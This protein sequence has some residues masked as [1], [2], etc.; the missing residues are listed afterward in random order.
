MTQQMTGQRT[1]VVYHA[2]CLDGFGAAWAAH[3]SLGDNNV[4]YLPASYG[5]PPPNFRTESRIFILDFSYPREITLE[6]IGQHQVTVLDHHE[7][8]EESIGDLPG[9]LY[10]CTHSGAVLAWQHFH[11]KLPA[12]EILRYVE[13][14][15]LWKF[16]LPQ[17][18]EVDAALRSFPNDF[19]A[20]DA[21][22]RLPC[23]TEELAIQGKS[24]LRNNRRMAEMICSNTVTVEI[25]GHQTPVVN[26]PV[27]ASE[28]CEVLLE[29]H[30]EALFA[31]AYQDQK[32]RRKWSL[33]S[34][35]GQ[36][37]RVDRVAE[38]LDGGGHPHAAGFIQKIDPDHLVRETPA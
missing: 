18:R 37:F 36:D 1:Y 19:G 26:T 24:I 20:W 11:P 5:N 9:C 28:A 17:S 15:D 33:R 7:T 10:D 30:P 4:E 3:L 2:G 14:R 31:A 22:A 27:L 6:L 21:L 29:Q 25:C 38:L 34:R 13:D 16:Q 23:V 32:G 12:P 35:E 8:A